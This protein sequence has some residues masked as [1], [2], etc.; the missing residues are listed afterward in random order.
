METGKELLRTELV[1][2]TWGNISCRLDSDSFLR[3][4]A[5]GRFFIPAVSLILSALLV[6][7]IPMFSMKMKRG[8][9]K[10]TPIYRLR[11]GFMGVIFVSAVLVWLLGLNWSMA[12]LLIF[13]NL[14]IK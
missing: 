12:V 5:E 9:Q 8:A 10:N 2:R 13:L 11:V 1:A 7:E 3:I 4:W 6:S 14:L